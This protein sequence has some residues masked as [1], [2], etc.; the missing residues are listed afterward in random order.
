MEQLQCD[1]RVFVSGDI[2]P[3]V[4][5]TEIENI[6][7]ENTSVD[8]QNFL[9]PSDNTEMILRNESI[10][11][12]YEQNSFDHLNS[13]GD[14]ENDQGQESPEIDE[15]DEMNSQPLTPE[16]D[17]TLSYLQGNETHSSVTA[18]FINIP[19]VVQMIPPKKGATFD[20]YAAIHSKHKEISE[21]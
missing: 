15:E 10:E 2:P 18:V 16:D 3:R 19:A 8:P 6:D 14:I 17:S 21:K 9:M 13:Y 20:Y 12:E 11:P 1:M 7:N 4:I 5:S